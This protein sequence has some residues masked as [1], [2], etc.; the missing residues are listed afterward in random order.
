LQAIPALTKALQDTEG[1]VRVAAAL[2]LWQIDQ[3]SPEVIAELK[4]SLRN[5]DDKVRGLAA[6]AL[7]EMGPKAQQAAAA[8]ALT[9]ESSNEEEEVRLQ[10]AQALW[11]IEHRPEQILE[12]VRTLLKSRSAD[13]RQ[14]AAALLKQI[15]SQKS[16]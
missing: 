9:L 11:R 1:S 6:A 15:E 2:A 7:G 14:A 12:I 3:K 4:A 8:L 5:E 13:I 10:A 16:D